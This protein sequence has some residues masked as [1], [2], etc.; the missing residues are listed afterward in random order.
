M[1]EKVCGCRE[2]PFIRGEEGVEGSSV[3]VRQ[4]LDEFNVAFQ[5]R[6]DV[7]ELLELCA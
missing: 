3:R 5:G 6:Y 7:G 1:A 4:R 2:G